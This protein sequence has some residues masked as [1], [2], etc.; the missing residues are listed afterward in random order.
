MCMFAG[1]DVILIDTQRA[2]LPHICEMEQHQGANL[3]NPYSL[4]RHLDEFTKPDMLYKS[5]W[6]GVEFVGFVILA[7]DPDGRSV[8]LRRIFV[9]R[10]GCGYGASAI[11]CVD[12]ICWQ[13]LGRNRV[14]LDVFETNERAQRVYVKCGFKPFSKS[15]SNGRELVLYEREL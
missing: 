14:W 8:E 6:S 5:I 7:L 12:K 4:E 11:N 10:P 15:T 3:I 13:E 9:S 2:E 1:R